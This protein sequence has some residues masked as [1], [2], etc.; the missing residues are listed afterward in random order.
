MLSKINESEKKYFNLDAEITL[1]IKNFENDA[2]LY[3]LQYEIT[4]PFYIVK[5]EQ[6][7]NSYLKL[8]QEKHKISFS[9]P[10]LIDLQK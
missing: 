8:A 6:L 2:V 3:K 10:K 7:F 9:T 5:A 1:D 4:S